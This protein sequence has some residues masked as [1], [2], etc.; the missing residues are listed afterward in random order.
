MDFSEEQE[1]LESLKK[2]SKVIELSQFDDDCKNQIRQSILNAQNNASISNSENLI[3]QILKDHLLLLSSDFNI[4]VKVL[5]S[6][7]IEYKILE[8]IKIFVESTIKSSTLL[9]FMVNIEYILALFS[10]TNNTIIKN[11]I[12]EAMFGEVSRKND[13]GNIDFDKVPDILYL[14]FSPDSILFFRKMSIALLNENEGTYNQPE[15]EFEYTIICQR[16][17]NENTEPKENEVTDGKKY[18]VLKNGINRERSRNDR[19]IIIGKN[20]NC[21]IILPKENRDDA[22]DV[23][24]IIYIGHDNLYAIDC[25]ENSFT[26]LQL[27]EIVVEEHMKNIDEDEEEHKEIKDNE[28]NSKVKYD[29]PKN[30]IEIKEGMVFNFGRVINWHALGID[31][32]PHPQY[33]AGTPILI[34][35]KLIY[36]FLDG[37]VANEQRYLE[38]FKRS[39]VTNPSEEYAVTNSKDMRKKYNLIPSFRYFIFGRG[40]DGIAPDILCHDGFKG[41][42]YIPV[43]KRH[44]DIICTKDGHWYMLDMRSKNGTFLL[45]KDINSYKNKTFSRPFELFRSKEEKIANIIIA[46]KYRFLFKKNISNLV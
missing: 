42:S 1:R 33:N 13:Y 44:A 19:F 10:I 37:P 22:D 36:E 4:D 17:Y 30:G 35:S 7:L 39:S 40:G 26:M 8:L 21:D 41:K 14:I 32:I 3:I 20:D 34:N 5:E 9:D 31:N 12:S 27:K 2:Y 11:Y 16:A 15:S 18:L 28:N 43:G 45:L 38:T 46:N 6:P 29:V 24:L 25:L 23:S